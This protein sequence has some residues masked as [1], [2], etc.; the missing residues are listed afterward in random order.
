MCSF[1]PERPIYQLEGGV[2]GRTLGRVA[3]LRHFVDDLL[4]KEYYITEV[5]L[6]AGREI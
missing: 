5:L 4:C 6:Y 2:L 1:G 3:L